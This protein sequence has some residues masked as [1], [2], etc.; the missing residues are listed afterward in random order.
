[1]YTLVFYILLN[2]LKQKKKG[3]LKRINNRIFFKL[4]LK[5]KGKRNKYVDAINDDIQFCE[6]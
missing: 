5:S 3:K 2:I 4:V 6:I 1:M